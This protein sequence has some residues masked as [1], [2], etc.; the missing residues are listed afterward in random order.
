MCIVDT[1]IIKFLIDYD[2][3]TVASG[4]ILCFTYLLFFH[5]GHVFTYMHGHTS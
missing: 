5:L 1:E 4:L 2:G 3:R